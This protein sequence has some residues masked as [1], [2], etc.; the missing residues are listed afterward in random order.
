MGWSNRAGHVGAAVS[1]PPSTEDLPS[2]DQ[3]EA[4][5]MLAYRYIRDALLL[6]IRMDLLLPK[7]STYFLN[8]SEEYYA[9][10]KP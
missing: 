7:Y 1:A 4:E 8:K 3:A 6:Y 9:T 2:G 10:P 5:Q